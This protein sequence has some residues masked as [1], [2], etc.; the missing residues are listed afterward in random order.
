MNLVYTQGGNILLGRIA[1]NKEIIISVFLILL[2]LGYFYSATTIKTISKSLINAQ[3]VP[4]ILGVGLLILSIAEF[5]DNLRKQP[6]EKS[7]TCENANDPSERFQI[8][9]RIIITLASMAIY[10][11]L[12]RPVGFLLMT[13]IYMFVQISILNPAKKLDIFKTL[14]FSVVF[15]VVIYF[16]FVHVFKIMLP[17]GILSF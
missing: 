15:S 7:T 3:F 17:R 9:I 8:F 12:L 2:S 1:K 4:K 10:I 13:C 11:T 14:A 5:I 6:T 16:L